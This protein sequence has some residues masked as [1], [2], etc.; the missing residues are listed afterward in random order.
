MGLATQYPDITYG[1]VL[2][3]DIQG[4]ETGL[5]ATLHACVCAFA[6]TDRR[7]C[8]C[9]CVRACWCSC[10]QPEFIGGECNNQDSRLHAETISGDAATYPGFPSPPGA[11]ECSDR[12][13]A[14]EGECG[15]S[16]SV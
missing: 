13:Q 4:T 7:A 2:K 3:G 16:S 10:V 12:V 8:G 14:V 11:S 5:G 1:Q 15:D 9:A 6:A